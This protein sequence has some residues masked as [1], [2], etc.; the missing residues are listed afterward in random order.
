[1]G[2]WAH[3]RALIVRLVIA[4][5]GDR[6]GDGDDGSVGNLV[7]EAWARRWVV[8]AEQDSPRF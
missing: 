7:G 2:I 6:V 1:M 4:Q 5:S 8:F 3:V